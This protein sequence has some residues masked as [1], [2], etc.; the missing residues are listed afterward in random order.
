[1][2]A[3][4]LVVLAT[5]AIR[6]IAHLVLRF[7]EQALAFAFTLAYLVAGRLAFQLLGLADHSIFGSRHGE[8]LPV[9]PVR[10]R[11]EA[12]EPPHVSLMHGLYQP[13]R[14]FTMAECA[15][16]WVTRVTCKAQ[17]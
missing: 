6:G 8:L 12:Q 5:D 16:P 10:S 9:C 15:A 17:L 13:D 1:M 2:L 14:F 4:L 7:A 11:E 3:T